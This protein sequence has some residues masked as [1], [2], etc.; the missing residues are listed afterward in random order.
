M[1]MRRSGFLFTSR[2]RIARGC[3]W[4]GALFVCA[5][6]RPVRS[7]LL[8]WRSVRQCLRRSRR[9]W[10]R[11]GVCSTR[12]STTR[13]CRFST[14]RSLA[15]AAGHPRSRQPHRAH[16]GLRDAR[17]RALRHRQPRGRRRRL[18][19]ALGL[20]PGFALAEGVSPRVV[21]MLDEVRV[22]T[23]GAIEL[24]LDPPTPSWSSTACRGRLATAG[25][26]WRPARTRCA[27]R[28]T[29]FRA[30]RSARDRA[31]GTEPAAA[32]RPGAHGERRD[33]DHHAA[34]HR[35]L[36][37]RRLA[38]AHRPG[39]RRQ[40]A[41]PRS[42]R[43]CRCRSNRSPP[44]VLSDLTTGTFDVEFRRDCYVTERRR[45]SIGELRRPQRGAGDAEAAVG[46]LVLESEP[47]GATV[48]IDGEAR[49]EAPATIDGVCAGTHVIEFRSS[50]GRS[51]ER[52]SLEP[53]SQPHHPRPRAARLCA[54]HRRSRH[55][56]RPAPGRRARLRRGRDRRALRAAGRRVEGSAR[57]K[58]RD[59]R[60]VR[61]RRR[62]TPSRPT[63]LRDRLRRLAEGLGRAGACVGA[64]RAAWRQRSA[65]CAAHARQHRAGR[66]HRDPRSARQRQT[67][68][69]SAADAAGPHPRI[70][71]G[72]A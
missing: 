39:R 34:G 6:A 50:V 5:R 45:I 32:R 40:A 51:V 63:D 52:I 69:G 15:R 70:A 22:A 3:A 61:R 57:A 12:S 13:R 33:D 24:T 26:P 36:R 17:A 65:A 19:R 7:C 23:I 66:D 35:S 62:S 30:D 8:C 72:D 10:S 42:P 31:G 16:L 25:W 55:G 67:G 60:V 56:G 53:G 68:A 71:G 11:G 14:A 64:A 58:R 41:P 21:A 43:S 38:R 44:L 54:A 59:G 1:T 27:C 47:A 18:S 2:G 4:R 48:L 49:G 20:E 46:T 9:I 28:G 37:Q 29:G